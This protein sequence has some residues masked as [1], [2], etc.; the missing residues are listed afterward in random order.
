M[1]TY[2]K[3]PVRRE[4]ENPELRKR[5][6]RIA[7]RVL[8]SE[9]DSEDAAHDAVV[10]ALAAAE[11]FRND[12]QV[13]TWMHRI[14]VN[15]SLMALRK[16]QR[17]NRHMGALGNAGVAGLPVGWALGGDATSVESQV[18][19]ADSR[20]RVRE[21]VQKLPEDYKTVIEHCVYEE[22]TAEEA[23]RALHLTP[24]AVRT[25]VGR[26]RKRLQDLL[27]ADMLAAA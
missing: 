6:V 8:R 1:G 11:R 20:G 25:R 13:T 5:L 3:N 15:A 16:S 7:G 21:A 4:L 2:K 24:S 12:S 10:Q 27:S 19:E 26:A 14:A 23:A 17:A 22:E 18:F 9:E